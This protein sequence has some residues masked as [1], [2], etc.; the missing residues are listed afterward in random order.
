VI[1]LKR[2]IR[3]ENDIKLSRARLSR[4]ES[5]ATFV[6]I[7][8]SSGKTSTCR[9]LSHI[10]AG[11]AAVHRCFTRG[12]SRVVGDRW[13]VKNLTT[14][15][16]E[17]R[18]VVC[19]L[20]SW[21]PGTLQPQI[22]LVRPSVGVVT[23]VALEH[24]SNFR[25]L[26]AVAEE[27]R[28]LIEAL[29]KNGLA[30]LNHDDPRVLS[31]ASHTQARVVT[32]GSSGGDYRIVRTEASLPGALSVTV[33]HKGETFEIK[34]RLSGAH[35]SLAVTAA[36]ACAHQLGAPASLIKERLA[37]FRPVFGR[38]S[39]HFIK[40][41]PVF[42]AD[43]AKAPY[44]SIYLPIN[45]MAGFS[46]PR[47]RIVIGQIADFAGQ[48][49]S[50]YRDVY[51]ASRLVA[52]QVIFVGDNA[53]RSKA[54]ADEIATQKFVE[55]RTVV[56]ASEYVKE[57]AI[58]GEI[59]LLKSARNLHLERIF[60]NFKNSVQC[61]EQCCG[62]RRDCVRCGCFGIPFAQQRKMRESVGG[63]LKATEASNRNPS[64]SLGP[65]SLPKSSSN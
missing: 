27:K 65:Q 42:I 52:D 21:G 57:T 22:E 31:M 9:M 28:K 37:R 29:P 19:E 41:G 15:S 6:G 54:T 34:T 4:N 55:K 20:G 14:I 56:E 43:T 39:I 5:R 63:D 33:A 13:S 53:H 59:I 44:H 7:T 46:A 8:G 30:V 49:P 25:T 26:D 61:W 62:K 64:D 51:R 3:I 45:M 2:L 17:H 58:P 35:S 40:H 11:L 1:F 18:Y 60:L 50:K 38:C 16:P 12:K 10:L 24:Y 23:L 32:F 48:A 36:F 47:R